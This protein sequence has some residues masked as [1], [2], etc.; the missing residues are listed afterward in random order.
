[1]AGALNLSK[2]EAESGGS[3]RVGG[4][5]DLHVELQGS[6]QEPRLHS[7]T[8][9]QKE[10]EIK[11]KKKRNLG[12]VWWCTAETAAVGHMNRKMDSLR[13]ASTT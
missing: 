1:M 2:G 3:L 4:Q 9:S 10:K 12:S 6:S 7:E 11:R 8:L 13:P 5:A